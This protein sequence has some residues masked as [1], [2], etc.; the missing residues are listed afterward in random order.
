L[1]SAHSVAPAGKTMKCKRLAYF[2]HKT[3]LNKH[4]H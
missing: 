3:V 4:L 2:H 1:T